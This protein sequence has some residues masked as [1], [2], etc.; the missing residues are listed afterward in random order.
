M[1]GGIYIYLVEG[2]EVRVDRARRT[3]DVTARVGDVTLYL[4]RTTATALHTALG[5]ALSPSADETE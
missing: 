4:P 5:A 2:D 3:D 1:I